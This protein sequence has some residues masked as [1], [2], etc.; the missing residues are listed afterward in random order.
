MLAG[1]VG[2]STPGALLKGFRQ[3]QGQGTR[4]TRQQ[5]RQGSRPTQLT[6]RSVL[7]EASK[8]LGQAENWSEGVRQF[9]QH[10]MM[11]VLTGPTPGA[12]QSIAAQH[13]AR[14]V[15]LS[16]CWSRSLA[17][18]EGGIPSP[19][20]NESTGVSSSDANLGAANPAAANMAY[21]EEL[22]PKESAPASRV[23]RPADQHSSTS[24]GS[25]REY[26]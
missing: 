1:Y 24:H 26:Y 25:S 6:S 17:Q 7:A 4:P 10:R 14:S 21:V 12:C 8:S 18:P 9:A 13:S 22:S 2:L 3:L 20:S 16:Q 11:N 19:S 15:Y 23:N 5:T